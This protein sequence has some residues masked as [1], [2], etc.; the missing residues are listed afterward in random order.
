MKKSSKLQKRISKIAN[1]DSNALV[2]GDGFGSFEEIYV[3]FHTTFIIDK[4][5]PKIKSKKIIFR[6]D[7]KNLE[8]LSDIRVIFVDESQLSNLSSLGLICRKFHPLILIE[9]DKVIEREISKP[10]WSWGWRP[11]DQQGFFHV[12]KKML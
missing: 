12:W 5:R 8:N 10:I 1:T 9:G 7:Y 2:L 4:E 6:E 3:L 11:V